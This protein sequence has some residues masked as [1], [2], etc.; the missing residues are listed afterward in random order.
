M[1]KVGMI[2][3]VIVALG[4]FIG[5]ICVIT[6]IEKVPVGYEGVVYSLNGGV[7]ENTLS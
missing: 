2:G 3:G 4:L 6:S 1:K 7:Q 5:L